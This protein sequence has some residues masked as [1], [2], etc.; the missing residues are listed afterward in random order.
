VNGRRVAALAWALCTLMAVPSAV[1]LVLGP[2][3]PVPG[4]LLGGVGG[5]AFLVLSLAF[6]SVGAIVAARVPGNPIGWIFCL[7]GV[8][9]GATVLAYGYANYGLHARSDPL[10]GATAAAWF[11]IGPSEALAPLLGLS[12]LLFPDGRLPSS[13]W[14]PAAYVLALAAALL[15]VTDVLRP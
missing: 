15:L 2:G 7:I 9:A 6:A 5:V 1:L 11:S 3:R 13:R 14:R 12:L 8:L 10:P 4:D